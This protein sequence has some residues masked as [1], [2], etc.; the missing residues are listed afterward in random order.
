MNV[1]IATGS[2]NGEILRYVDGAWTQLGKV[3]KEQLGP[4]PWR[5]F[6]SWETYEEASNRDSAVRALLV[7]L[8]VD[9]DEYQPGATA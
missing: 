7:A 2:R 6:S 1:V 3:R 9:P 4:N 5:A 8:G